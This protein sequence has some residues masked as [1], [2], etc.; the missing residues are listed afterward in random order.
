MRPTKQ[1]YARVRRLLD[2]D[3]ERGRRMGEF[4]MRELRFVRYGPVV[5]HRV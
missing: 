2:T 5:V 4:V 1:M 3:P